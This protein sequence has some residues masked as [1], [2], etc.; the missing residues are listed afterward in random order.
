MDCGEPASSGFYKTGL[1]YHVIDRIFISHLH[2]DHV[3][4]LFMMIQ[5]LWLKRMRKDLPVS[6]PTDGIAPIRQ[7]INAACIFDELLSF[8]LHFEPLRAG[9][10]VQTGDVRVTPFATT[11]L[12][13][14]RQRFAQKY[15]LGYEAFCFLIEATGLRIGHTADV[16][17]VEDLAPLVAQPLDLLVCELAH[18]APER[19]FQYL[20]GRQIRRCVF[21][22]LTQKQTAQV[23]QLRLMAANYLGSAELC[24]AHDGEEI[25]F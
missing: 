14:F 8:R 11:H 20:Q 4:G 24:F 10:P 12:R 13:S 7:L 19:L 6:L 9:E 1:P 23:E 15:A 18:L 3:G 25:A 22:H 2:F 16:G 5:S 17:A 21:I